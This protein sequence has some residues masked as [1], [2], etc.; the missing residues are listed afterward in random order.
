MNEAERLRRLYPWMTQ[1][2]IVDK[3]RSVSAARTSMPAHRKA[4]LDT[5]AG[6]E[7]AGRYNV[8]YG[9]QRFSDY[10]KHPG[11][12]VPIQSGPNVG[13]TS[14]AA[15]KYQFIK[16]TWNTYQQKLGLKDFSPASQDQ[17]AW[18]LARDTYGP[19]LDAVL[20]SGDPKAIAGVGK[21]LRGQ[22][23]SLPGGIEQGTTTD[24]FTSTF[25]K[26]LGSLPAPIPIET[27]AVNNQLAATQAAA[28]P[29]AAKSPFSGLMQMMM[30]DNMMA[31]A[32]PSPTH[33]VV[34]QETPSP[35]A[36]MTPMDIIE[37]T[38]ASSHTPDW[39][40]RR[41]QRGFV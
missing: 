35:A 11:I 4:L 7:S 24:K 26:N 41:R 37:Q 40:R 27:T 36:A 28:A 39:Y 3:L 16:P 5:I 20:Q 14:S 25:F 12:N 22:W 6:P 17:A 10:S 18:A 1:Q 9:G 38:A 30:L 33:S 34:H 15:G 32:A 21:A 29:A 23:T 2:Q 31:S 13:K 8:V 19:N